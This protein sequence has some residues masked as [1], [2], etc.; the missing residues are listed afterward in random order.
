M[1]PRFLG[2]IFDLDG[3][4]L[5]T[6]P[7]YYHACS[8]VVIALGAQYSDAIHTSQLLGRAER[9][10]SAR[11]IEHLSLDLSVDEFLS[12]RD[13]ILSVEMPRVTPL[14]GALVML[15]RLHKRLPMSIA[16]SSMR[17]HLHLKRCNN[18]DLFALV[19]TVLCGDDE[20]VKGLSKPHPAI[21]LAAAASLG[22]DPARCIAFE[23]SLAGM[24]SAK[25]A[26]MFVVAVPDPRL[27]P[28]DVAQCAPD[29]TVSSLSDL[30]VD[31]MFGLDAST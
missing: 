20:S 30:N 1:P 17:S 23:D 11:L 29:V 9:E 7:L 16:T 22:I 3:T 31:E 12:R 21:F 6:E 14:P 4:L 2:A 15:R 5:D 28:A 8:T 19:D 26:G 10:G 18:E 13:T 25:A 27:A 24:R